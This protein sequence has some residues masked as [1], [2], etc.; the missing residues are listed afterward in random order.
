MRAWLE[1]KR[2]FGTGYVSDAGMSGRPKMRASPHGA[3]SAKAL[4]GTDRDKIGPNAS[5]RL[6]LDRDQTGLVVANYKRH[7]GQINPLRL[8]LSPPFSL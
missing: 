8:P 3:R 5:W 1:S 6:G 7:E 4:T 2:S